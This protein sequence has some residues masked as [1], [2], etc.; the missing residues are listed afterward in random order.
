MQRELKMRNKKFKMIFSIIT[1]FLI[2]LPLTNAG[3]FIVDPEQKYLE[4]ILIHDYLEGG[5]LDEKNGIKILH[6]N[7]SYYEMGFQH[8]YLLKEEIETN[9][10]ILLPYY[11]KHGYPYDK[12]LNV[13]EI[14]DDYLPDFYKEELQGLADGSGMSFE[15]V[16]VFNTMPALFNHLFACCELSI[17]GDATVDGKLYHIRSLDWTLGLKDP[18]TQIPFQDNIVLFVRNPEIG[19]ASMYPEF[20]GDIT[21]WSGVN[22]KGIAVGEDTCLTHDVTYKGI[23][24]A[25]RMRMV[26][27]FA[28]NY[29]KAIE[30]LVSN[31]T[32]GTNFVLSDG[33]V[34]IGYA[35]DQTANISYVG[36]WDDPVEGTPPFW[37]IKDAIRRTP[38][39]ISPE[40]AA[41]ELRRVRYDP[42]GLL[43]FI[44]AFTGKS[45]MY[46][47]WMHYKALSDEIEKRYGTLDLNN[48]MALLRDVYNGKTNLWEFLVSK[49][50]HKWSCLS[51]FV[52]CPENGDML[53]SFAGP[54]TRACENPVHY[55]NIFNLLQEEPPEINS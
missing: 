6:L 37:Q 35:L 21:C 20:A 11:E 13:W 40:C 43:P 42:S 28:D 50:A 24:P 48:S 55:F 46:T 51:Q 47:T 1:F 9:L 26:L 39:F 41:V 31:R 32:C 4:K 3:N 12:I 45:Y 33:N 7:G 29:E 5:W 30:I 17:W 54:N 36:K 18:E 25:F 15:D 34:P 38:M 52:T 10:R 53:I 23:C 49:I 8:G 27:D 44:W 16:A 22:E 19:Y 2:A 14:M